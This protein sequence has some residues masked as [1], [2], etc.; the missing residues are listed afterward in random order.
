MKA[1]TKTAL[2]ATIIL[3]SLQLKAYDPPP[4]PPPN[5]GNPNGNPVGGGAPIGGGMFILLGIGSVYGGYKG[6][7][8]YQEKKKKLID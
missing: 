6:Y 1:I 2:I 4:P 5:G 8:I 7:K 3:F